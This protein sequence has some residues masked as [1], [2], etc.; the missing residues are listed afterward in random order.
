MHT[1]RIEARRQVEQPAVHRPGNTG[2]ARHSIGCPPADRDGFAAPRRNRVKPAR[3]QR[4][5]LATLAFEKIFERPMAPPA[6]GL[7]YRRT[8]GKRAGVSGRPESQLQEDNPE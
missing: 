4:E 8:G 1:W 6:G 2:T 5:M 7:R 3:A